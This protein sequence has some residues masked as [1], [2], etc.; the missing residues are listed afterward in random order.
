MQ[1]ALEISH[2]DV[3]GLI[4]I[5]MEKSVFFIPPFTED[6]FRWKTAYALSKILDA[7]DALTSFSAF[8]GR[9]TGNTLRTLHSRQ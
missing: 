3:G 7:F 6:C 2:S 9:Q 4:K 1:A 8:I 5:G